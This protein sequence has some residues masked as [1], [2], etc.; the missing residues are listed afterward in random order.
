MLLR[1]PNRTQCPEKIPWSEVVCPGCG[2][3]AGFGARVKAFFSRLTLIA[4]PSC[5]RDVPWS[6]K[7]CPGCGEAMTVE[8][9]FRSGDFLGGERLRRLARTTDAAT[10]KKLQRWF[11]AASILLLLAL[12]AVDSAV[13]RSDSHYVLLATF[14]PLIFLFAIVFTPYRMRMAL[15]H[16]TSGLFK[17]AVLLNVVNFAVALKLLIGAFEDRAEA[18]ALIIGVMVVSLVL[19]KLFVVH[20]WLWLVW[21]FY[22]QGFGPSHDPQD[23][24]GHKVKVDLG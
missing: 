20:L 12:N 2:A 6:K 16:R 15:A 7:S 10:R 21:L 17:C 3:A 23:E 14:L 11:F 9:M 8:A 22:F 13:E 18:L 24:Q 4:C 5:R 1:C 19:L